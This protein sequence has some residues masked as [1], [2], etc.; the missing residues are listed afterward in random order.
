M[1]LSSVEVSCTAKGKHIEDRCKKINESIEKQ[2]VWLPM[3]AQDTLEHMT[4]VNPVQP[5]ILQTEAK[6]SES[7]AKSHPRVERLAPPVNLYWI[8]AWS[9]WPWLV[10]ALTGSTLDRSTLAGLGLVGGAVMSSPGAAAHTP[11]T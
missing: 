8:M 11:S 10:F 6:L 3:H 4:V 5:C 2:P 1:Y 9:V 7:D